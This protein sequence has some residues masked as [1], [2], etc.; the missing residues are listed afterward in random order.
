M[1]ARDLLKI[2]RNL[3]AQAKVEAAR[4]A[5]ARAVDCETRAARLVRLADRL[6]K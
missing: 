1:N 5:P 3:Q 2:A 4:G 6:S